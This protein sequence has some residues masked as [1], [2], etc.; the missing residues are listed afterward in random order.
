MDRGIYFATKV[1]KMKILDA[2]THLD[3]IT[4]KYRRDVDGCICCATREDDWQN[5]VDLMNDD[6]RVYGAFGV[7]PWFV[8]SIVCDF[9][10]QLEELL[11]QNPNYMVG[12]IGLDKYKPDMKRQVEIFITQF[13]IAVKLKRTVSLHCVGAWDKVFYILKQYKKSEL[14]MIIVHA[15]NENDDVLGNLSKYENMYFSLSKN[16]INGGKCRIEQIPQNRILVESDGKKDVVLFKI[17][18]TISYIKNEPNMANIIY[19]NTQRILKN[20]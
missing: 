8:D 7:H 5:I 12:E 15:F 3:Y 9:D 18:D 1:L 17:I 16:S 6:N 13:N 19:E 11:N 10:K 20:G 14:P 2:H 4:Q